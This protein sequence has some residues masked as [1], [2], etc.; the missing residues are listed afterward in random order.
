M[1]LSQAVALQSFQVDATP[2]AIAA[3]PAQLDVGTGGEGITR[4]AEQAQFAL[5]GAA[6]PLGALL[7]P[8]RRRPLTTGEM[9]TLQA[10]VS[11]YSVTLI[12]LS[13]LAQS[14]GSAI[15]SITQ[16]T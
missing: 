5:Q 15:Q 12:T 8:T 4:L 16:R 11:D 6:A 1:M 14:V 2:P 10:A 3:T 13:H 9:L 7:D